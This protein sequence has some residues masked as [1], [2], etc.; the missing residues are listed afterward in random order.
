MFG[1]KIIW[2]DDYEVSDDKKEL[3]NTIESCIRDLININYDI[4]KLRD[5]ELL[6]NDWDNVSGNLTCL[7]NKKMR[8]IDYWLPL[9]VNEFFNTG[10]FKFKVKL[11]YGRVFVIDGLVNIILS[12]FSSNTLGN[13]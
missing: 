3:L 5:S 8:I 9:L 2:Y 10:L 1:K 11:S 12:L 13:L 7:Y 6:C 4:L